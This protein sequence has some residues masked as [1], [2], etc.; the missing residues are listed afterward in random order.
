MGERMRGFNWWRTPVG[1]PEAW[2][3]A[4]RTVVQIMLAAKQPMFTVW[5]AE[6]TLIYNDAYMTLLGAKD[7]TALGR[8]FLDVWDEARVDR[9]YPRGRVR[10]ASSEG[11]RRG[12]TRTCAV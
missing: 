4:L 1:A 5:G 7:P 9:N 10:S 2:P 6:R 12:A 11:V 3:S 8:S